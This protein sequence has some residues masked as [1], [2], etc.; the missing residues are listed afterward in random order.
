M[1]DSIAD[2]TFRQRLATYSLSELEDVLAHVDRDTFPERERF[3]TEE[4]EARLSSINEENVP[5]SIQADNPPGFLRRLGVSL[6]DASI[7][8]VIPYI[9]LYFI[10]KVIYTPLGNN[11]LVQY[12]FPPDAPQR[13]GGRGGRG[14]RGGSNDIWS[15]IVGVWDGVFGFFAGIISQEPEAIS[16]LV[17]VVEYFVLYLVLRLFW[18]CLQLRKSGA[19]LGMQELGIKLIQ[20]DGTTPNTFRVGVRFMLQYILFV[21]TLGIGGLWMF[22]DKEKRAFHD[23]LL[24][25]R[26]V[27]VSRSWEK[28]NQDRI[29]D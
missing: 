18:T 1:E 29:F 28:S 19:T 2:T 5:S 26:L 22:W 17:V 14:G 7:Q 9:V 25:M 11:A 6:V 13:G 8:V 20:N 21:F 24:G 4:I 15:D 23:R 10:V 16:T 12:L 27:R 3:V